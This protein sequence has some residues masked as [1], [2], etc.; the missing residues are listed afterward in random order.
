[1]IT[2][3]QAFYLDKAGYSTQKSTIKT[4]DLFIDGLRFKSDL[5]IGIINYEKGLLMR[6]GV[7]SKRIKVKYHVK[8]RDRI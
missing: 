1:M 2:K 5:P 6:S 7:I 8:L 4:F 3:E